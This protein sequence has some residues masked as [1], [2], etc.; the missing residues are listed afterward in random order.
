MHNVESFVKEPRHTNYLYM[1]PQD[2]S[3]RGLKEGSLARVESKTG[4]VHAQV[5]CSDEL[6]VGTVA[7]PHGWGHASADGLSV[8]RTTAGVNANVLS[9]DG[10]AGVEPL[11][12]MV[13]LTGIPVHVQRVDGLARETER[14]EG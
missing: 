12:G 7:L 11:S 13:H 5:R 10:P 2:A 8:A 9:A 4:R 6:M 3:A 14:A 1:H